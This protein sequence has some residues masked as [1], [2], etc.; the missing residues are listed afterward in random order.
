VAAGLGY[1][2]F[3]VAPFW[4]TPH[5][6]GPREYGFHGLVTL[7]ANCYLIAGLAF[8]AY[9]ARRA[10]LVMT[11]APPPPDGPQPWRANPLTSTSRKP[12]LTSSL[13]V[14]WYCA[15]VNPCRAA[16]PGPADCSQI[17]AY[18]ASPFRL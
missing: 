4:Y 13:K 2:L 18:R 9:M 11:A 1:L 6:G 3:A 16:K 10:Y 5:S 14:C 8:L 12:W 7:V 17:A 15:A